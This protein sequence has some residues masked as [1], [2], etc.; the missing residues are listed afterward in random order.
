MAPVNDGS[1]GRHSADDGA[2]D[3]ARVSYLSGDDGVA[4]DAADQAELDELR[5]LLADPTLWAEPPAALEDSVVGLIAAESAGARRTELAGADSDVGNAT[6]VSQAAD[7]LDAAG[8]SRDD[9]PVPATTDPFAATGPFPA[10]T[11][12]APLAAVN[13]DGTPIDLAAARE[14][15]VARDNARAAGGAARRRWARPG[16][17]VAAAAAVIAVALTGV[18]LL[19]DTGTPQRRFDVA[20]SATELAPGA[21]GDASMVKT[22]SGWEIHLQ[23]TGLPRLDNGA[24]YQAWLRNADGVLVPI[25]SFNEGTDVTLWAGVSPETFSTFT[26][27]K[28]TADGNQ[29]SSGQRVMSGSAVEQH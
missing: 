12:A 20:L 8:P 11:D 29:D 18:L 4:L 5:A 10:I 19:R 13:D 25:G 24:F 23:A 27:T 3:D 16:I 22:D 7:A 28:E 6:D 9:R 2:T 1:G 26:I 17:L 21:S 15:R 14:R